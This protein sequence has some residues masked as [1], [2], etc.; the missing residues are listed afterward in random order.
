[1]KNCY[2]AG[3]SMEFVSHVLGWSQDILERKIFPEHTVALHLQRWEKKKKFWKYLWVTLSKSFIISLSMKPVRA[4]IAT[5]SADHLFRNYG[6]FLMDGFSPLKGNVMGLNSQWPCWDGETDPSGRVSQIC[7]FY[8]LRNNKHHLLTELERP[9][10]SV[11]Q[12]VSAGFLQD[13]QD[14]SGLW[15]NFCALIICQFVEAFLD[16]ARVQLLR[17]PC[18]RAHEEGEKRQLQKRRLL[19]TCRRTNQHLFFPSTQSHKTFLQ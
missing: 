5:I 6:T 10:L 18:T 12:R 11:L 17:H 13:G 4:I 19:K 2:A 15:R 7:R 8:P 14:R 16:V 9:L 1:M 3:K